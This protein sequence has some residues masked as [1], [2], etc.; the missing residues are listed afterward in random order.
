MQKLIAVM[1]SQWNSCI[2]DERKVY[3]TVVNIGEKIRKLR[4][5]DFTGHPCTVSWSVISGGQ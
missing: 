1:V 2:Y 3:M 4:K 5:G